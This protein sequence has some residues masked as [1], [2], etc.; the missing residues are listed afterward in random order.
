[1]INVF[2]DFIIII[3]YQWLLSLT[4]WAHLALSK[5]GGEFW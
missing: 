5:N 3:H 4:W 1:M 2:Y